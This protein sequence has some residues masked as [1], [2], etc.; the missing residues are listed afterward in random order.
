MT[1]T[2][3][4]LT[5]RDLL[6]YR[7]LEDHVLSPDGSQVA[8]TVTTVEG[9]D[10][11]Y[12]SAIWLI[13]TEGG[14]L[15]Q[16]TDDETSATSPRWRPDGRAL[17]FRSDCGDVSQVSLL[18]LAGGEPSQLTS[19]GA[20]V[21]DFAWSPDGRSLVVVSPGQEKPD[22]NS[23]TRHVTRLHYKGDGVGLLPDLHNH[24]WLVPIDG[25]TPP[26]QLTDTGEDDASPAWS[27][28]G[29]RIAFNRTRPS[30][31]GSAPFSDIW[32]LD[33]ATGEERNLT[34]GRGPCFGPAW[35]PDG[36]TLAFAGHTEPND[37]WW[38]KDYGIWTIPAAGGDATE[39]T[40]GFGRIAARAVFGDPWRGIAWPSA[41]WSADG[42]RL[43]FLATRGGEVHVHTAPATGGDVRPLTEG[44]AVVTDL[45]V[46][47]SGIVFSRMTGTEPADLWSVPVAGGGPK[48]LTDLNRD[49]LNEVAIAEAERFCFDSH[50]GRSIE[51]WLLPPANFDPTGSAKHPLVLSIHGGPHGAYGEAFHHSFQTFSAVDCFVLYVNPRGSQG[52]G[53]E[54]ALSVIGDWGGGDFKDLMAAI[55]HVLAR[56][57]VDPTRLGAW[58]TSY[59]GYM[60]SWIA[61]NTDRFAAIVSCLPVT[62]LISFYGTSDIGHYFAPFEMGCQPWEDR[63]RY[64]RMSPLTY[65]EK[66]VTPLLLVHHEQDLR[67]PIAQSEQFYTTLKSLGRVVEFL[68]VDDASHGVVPPK[69][70][71]SELIDLEAA[72]D[73]FGRYL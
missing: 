72:H 44:R 12:R 11:R 56:G 60:T 64:V 29:S 1:S 5:S 71:H 70:A 13:S 37:I 15:R 47:N 26:R 38:G 34:D 45:A 30:Q 69:R 2:R 49:L 63:D 46:G 31:A 55:D 57:R 66:V 59:G 42:R 52:Y 23:A 25:N 9:D 54:F 7:L 4:P 27:P 24:L 43:F 53:E 41:R 8:F 28:D 36:T 50:D 68:R 39:I 32:V 61:G 73:W 14:D 22:P 19:L 17:A 58:G 16:L 67:C 6:R 21:S 20:G 3:R 35:S 10:H 62:D 33:V 48:R 65:A 40:A 51:A 18:D